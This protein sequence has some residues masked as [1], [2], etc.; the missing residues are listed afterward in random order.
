MGIES[1]V[2]KSTFPPTGQA[3]MRREETGYGAGEDRGILV[4]T[5]G[6]EPATT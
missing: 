1:I 5:A 3:G 6:F 2:S 4:G